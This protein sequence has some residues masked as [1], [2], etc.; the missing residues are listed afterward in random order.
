[1]TVHG[2]A[3]ALAAA[4]LIGSDVRHGRG[5]IATDLIGAE[6]NMREAGRELEALLADGARRRAMREN[7]E[8]RPA[9]DAAERIVESLAP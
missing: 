5:V 6:D 8:K 3:G 4:A 7:L 1:M 9:P 2:R